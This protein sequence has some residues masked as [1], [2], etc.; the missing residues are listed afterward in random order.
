MALNNFDDDDQYRPSMNLFGE[1]E[2]GQPVDD[3]SGSGL[4]PFSE[5]EGAPEP[6]P[7]KKPSAGIS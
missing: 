7:E 6:E 1:P 2:P 3:G 5:G 4:P